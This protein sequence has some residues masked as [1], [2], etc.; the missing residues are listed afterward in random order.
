[1]IYDYAAT[2]PRLYFGFRTALKACAIE[3]KTVSIYILSKGGKVADVVNKLHNH[4]LLSTIY[5]IKRPHVLKEV[6]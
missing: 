5:A 4:G 2:C 1:M 3:F 6:P